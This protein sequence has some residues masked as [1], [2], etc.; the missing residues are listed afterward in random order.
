MF[1]KKSGDLAESKNLSKGEVHVGNF[2]PYSVHLAPDIIKL[3]GSG[4]VLATWRLHGVTFETASP[5]Q[6]SAA[7]R[8]LVNFLHG[9]RGSVLSGCTA[10]D[11]STRMCFT[12]DFPAI[13]PKA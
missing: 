8:E 12:A 11:A 5:E 10:S 3:R 4:D 7:K 6:I 1:F 2:I 13:S 9:V